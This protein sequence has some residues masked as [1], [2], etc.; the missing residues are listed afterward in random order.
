[1]GV[2]G[3]AGRL[4]WRGRRG[5][6]RRLGGQRRQARVPLPRGLT[7]A[8]DGQQVKGVQ[9]R[10]LGEVEGGQGERDREGRGWRRWR[11]E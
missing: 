5:L 8:V 9:G 6:L 4:G 3:W 11:R 1:M 7:S 2:G 10:G